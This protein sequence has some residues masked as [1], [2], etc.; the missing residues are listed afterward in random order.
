[1]ARSRPRCRAIAE[2]VQTRARSACA[3]CPPLQ[4]QVWGETPERHQWRD[5]SLPGHHVILPLCP[6]S[7]CCHLLCQLGRPEG[8]A[9]VRVAGPAASTAR[10]VHR[11]LDV[12]RG[13]RPCAAWSRRRTCSGSRPAGWRSSWPPSGSRSRAGRR[14][15]GWRPTW[16]R[17]SR[18]SGPGRWTR[19]RQRSSHPRAAGRHKQRP[20]GLGRGDRRDPAW[21]DVAAVPDSLRREPDVGDAEDVLAVGEGDAAQ[22]LRPGAAWGAHLRAPTGSSDRG[23]QPCKGRQMT[24]STC[25]SGFFAPLPLPSVTGAVPALPYLTLGCEVYGRYPS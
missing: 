14:C 9:V 24:M 18:R 20:R 25:E 5:P 15:P 23:P 8:D 7:T 3:S 10:Y 13:R 22:R 2:I 4:E 16:T 11:H 21:C 17:S 19:A 12:R 1:M 6:V